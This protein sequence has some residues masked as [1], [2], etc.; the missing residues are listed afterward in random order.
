M[1]ASWCCC[2]SGKS[3]HTS[4]C[5]RALACINLVIMAV[6]AT[7][8]FALAEQAPKK[9]EAK[10]RS[11]CAVSGNARFGT[12]RS[13]SAGSSDS[14]SAADTRSEGCLS[15]HGEGPLSGR[16]WL[17]SQ[18]PV[19]CRQVQAAFDT[20]AS[21]EVREAL[22]QELHGR[23]AKAMRDAHANHVL[24]KCIATMPPASLQFMVDELLAR[25]G[26]ASQAAR[27]RYACR[28]VQQ[29]LQKCGADLASSL[30]EVLLRD[31]VT[32]ACH[33]I[34]NFAIKQ[35][36][37]WG[38]EDQRYRLVRMIE[39]NMRTI[40]H[41]TM[42]ASVVTVAMEHAASEDKVWIARAALQEPELLACLARGRY[43]DAAVLR[44][45]EVLG[46]RERAQV[47]SALKASMAAGGAPK[48]GRLVAEYLQALEAGM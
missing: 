12:W 38:T 17:L 29:L 26:L 41:S 10:V 6:A 3:F 21:D 28:I 22:A 46:S 5:R 43:G 48:L 32:L 37:Q 23:V 16:V 40:C 33:T 24:Q 19:G 8:V 35:L 20:A 13:E 18:D 9:Y 1:V 27:H 14:T 4:W 15:S 7:S 45:M 39:R 25:E 11:G 36:V 44:M 30:V 34:G 42:G 47:C 31:A 2:G